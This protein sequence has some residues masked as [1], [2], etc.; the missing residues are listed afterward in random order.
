MLVPLELKIIAG[1]FRI[2]SPDVAIGY[3][4]AACAK[5]VRRR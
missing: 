5:P 2:L 3:R 4:A 1:K